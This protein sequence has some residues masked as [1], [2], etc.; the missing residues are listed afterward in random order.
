[1]KFGEEWLRQWVNPSISSKQ[2]CEQ[3]TSFGCE[4]ECIR[5]NKIQV[6]DA[7]I[8]EIFSKKPY[9]VSNKLVIYKVCIL[10]NQKIFIIFSD[11]KYLL[12][13]SKIPIILSNNVFK[14]KNHIPKIN[15]FKNSV[16]NIFGSYHLLG[17][18]KGNHDIIILEKNAV[19][20]S[21]FCNYRRINR[22]IMKF[23][24]PFNRTD[25]HS[26]WGVSR[27]IA[28]LN[29][30][31]LP[32]LKYQNSL[33]H[34]NFIKNNINVSINNDFIQYIFCEIYSLDLKS[35]LPFY[36]QE[37]LIQSDLFTDNIIKNIINYVF[38]ETGHWFHILDLDNLCKQL[39]IDSLEEEKFII[40]KDNKKFFLPKSTIILRDLEKILSFEDMQYSEFIE[41]KNSTKNLFLG[42]IC[43]DPAF[44][45]RRSLVFPVINKNTDFT[46]YNI[47]PNVQKNIFEYTRTLI[48]TICSGNFSILKIYQMN[49][50]IFTPI[51][52]L[53]TLEKLNKISGIVFTKKD[54]IAILNDCYFLYSENNNVFY[55]TPPYW[56][57]DIIIIE[58]VISEIIRMYG[59]EKIISKPPK[60]CINNFLNKENRI[61]LSR[62]KLFLS[63]RGYFEIISYSFIN[64]T[65]HKFFRLKDKILKIKN[66]IS[67]EMSEMRSS[68]W[69]G[70]LNCVAYN[71]KR[72]QESIRVFETGLCFVSPKESSSSIFQDE[73]LSG[74]IS[75]FVGRRE[76]YIKNR[77]LDF[78]DLKGDIESI[79]NI[80]GKLNNIEFISEEFMG[81]CSKHSVGIYLYNQL[82]GR[83]G[84]LDSSFYDKFDL[85]DSV[86]LFEIMWKKIC[87]QSTINIQNISLLPNSTRDISIIIS[88]T[89]LSKDIVNL[90]LDNISI[91][92]THVYT[93]DVYTG[94]NIPIKKKSISVCF[95]FNSMNITLKESDINLNILKCINALKYKFGA[96]L[97]D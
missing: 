49:M 26:I 50:S 56:R 5:E 6:H 71:Q 23:F 65:L 72:Q 30:S 34:N 44:I 81:L 62:I 95:T 79:L 33:N 59:Y 1:M 55:I 38:I 13:G 67:N 39:Y 94:H 48:N 97:R 87:D 41:L 76:W 32:Q 69:I 37:R 24:V 80:C 53:L 22:Y 28:L 70:L 43:F 15:L 9:D 83:M 96:V 47:Y 8:G 7:V 75:G 57:T 4:A 16:N 25:L 82:I 51:I 36:M 66:P 14:K 60:K 78:Y 29:K 10:N 17:I 85:K 2:L 3:L 61:S 54:I 86:I 92:N 45:R 84:V 89:I 63:D 90:C 52:L 91:Q 35:I 42:S 40:N 58:D 12:I 21:N 46:R 64:A 19:V 73:Y 27:E 11:K 77:K 18:D 93:Y 74:A 31:Q 88:D 20:G 68:L